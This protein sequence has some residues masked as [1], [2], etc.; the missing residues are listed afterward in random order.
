MN[1]PQEAARGHSGGE[2]R[3]INIIIFLT[4]HILYLRERAGRDLFV[5]Q[6]LTEAVI[7]QCLENETCNSLEDEPEHTVDAEEW[8]N[9]Y[10]AEAEA[11]PSQP[12]TTGGRRKLSRK[13]RR[14][15]KRHRK[16]SR[17]RKCK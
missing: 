4:L 10:T 13:S 17:R 7:R 9:M 11:V 3:G 15:G 8:V 14:K 16:K 2:T 6:I 1:L 5:P 12:A